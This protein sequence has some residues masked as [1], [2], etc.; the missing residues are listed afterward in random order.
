M[1][2]QDIETEEFVIVAPILPGMRESWREMI[3]E[4]TGPRYEEWA[5]HHRRMG[6]TREV[7]W[8][9]RFDGMD[10]AI[11]SIDG[12]DPDEILDKMSNS[13]NPFD[14]WFRDRIIKVTGYL[15]D[16]PSELPAPELVGRYPRKAQ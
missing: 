16:Q 4:V 10:V 3:R 13:E 9:Q 15:E 2:G 5:D 11:V 7:I 8:E 12:V 1:Q 14:I 6:V